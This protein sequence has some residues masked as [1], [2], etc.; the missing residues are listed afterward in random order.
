M[1]K[2]TMYRKPSD[3]G[4]Y[5]IWG[6]SI[7][8][9]DLVVVWGKAVGSKQFKPWSFGSAAEAR[10]EAVNRSSK[11]VREGYEDTVSVYVEGNDFPCFDEEGFPMSHTSKPDEVEAEPTVG[12]IKSANVTAHW[13][14]MPQ[15]SKRSNKKEARS[16]LVKAKRILDRLIIA[17]LL[18]D[19]SFDARSVEV[20]SNAQVGK[21]RIDLDGEQTHLSGSLKIEYGVDPFLVILAW[22]KAIDASGEKLTM[23]VSDDDSREIGTNLKKLTEQLAAYG[24]DIDSVRERAERLDLLM[25]RFEISVGDDCEFDDFTL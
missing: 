7:Q 14:V 12:T 21:W 8:G 15:V 3:A 23:S 2:Y 9:T 10:R 22:K 24:E 19:A 11:K 1:F 16:L 18:P 4:G 6:F 20:G 17:G 13:N 5:K 25:P